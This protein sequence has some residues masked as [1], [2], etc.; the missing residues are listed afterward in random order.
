MIGPCHLFSRWR[1]DY[2]K[3][4]TLIDTRPEVFLPTFR[5]VSSVMT[6]SFDCPRCGKPLKAPEAAAGRT[7]ECK[8][9]HSK[10]TI[11]TGSEEK[12]ALEKHSSEK[13]PEG[14]ADKLAFDMISSNVRTRGNIPRASIL[15][16]SPSPEYLRARDQFS[17]Q[18]QKAIWLYECRLL[19]ES[20]LALVDFLVQSG[21][22]PLEKSAAMY[23]LGRINFEENNFTSAVKIWQMLVEEFPQ[24]YEGKLVDDRLSELLQILPGASTEYVDDI[25][26]SMYL[27]NGDHWIAGKGPGFYVD[28]AYINTIEAAVHWYD[29]TITEFPESA[30]ARLAHEQKLKT[31]IGWKD[32]DNFGMAYGAMGEFETYMPLVLEA[33]RAF[34]K[35]FP[36]APSLQPLRYQIA[37]LYWSQKDF[38]NTDVWLKQVIEN[39]SEEDSFYTDLATRRLHKLSAS[40]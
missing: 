18:L 28:T 39:G 1:V 12:G 40:I 19:R 9:C 27:K 23:L 38:V 32:A 7:A 36:L 22:H 26:A 4:S 10:I 17:P 15:V 8:F 16:E 3:D 37:Q 33:F 2:G 29:K 11:P 24:S 34:E 30:A 35:A 31:L 20:Q 21:I 25:R 13:K 5:Y 14:S 6:L